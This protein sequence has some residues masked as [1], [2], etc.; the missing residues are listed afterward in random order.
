MSDDDLEPST[1]SDLRQETRRLIVSDANGGY[2]PLRK[3]EKNRAYYSLTGEKIEDGS[4]GEVSYRLLDLLETEYGLDEVRNGEARDPWDHGGPLTKAEL[5]VLV[6]AL[7]KEAA[8]EEVG[9][10]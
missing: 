7:Q 2:H 1:V 9:D 4:N 8:D 3:H 10:A 6:E 5:T